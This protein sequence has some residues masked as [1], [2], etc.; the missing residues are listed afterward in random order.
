MVSSL[1]CLA[2]CYVGCTASA[3]LAPGQPGA[4]ACLARAAPHHS[5]PLTRASSAPRNAGLQAASTPASL[6]RAAS[7]RMPLQQRKVRSAEN[8]GHAHVHAVTSGAAEATPVVSTAFSLTMYQLIMPI[9]QTGV[10]K[11]CAGLISE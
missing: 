5:R 1:G 2:A 8:A 4:S 6:P 3:M 10:C 9:L 11:C 7:G